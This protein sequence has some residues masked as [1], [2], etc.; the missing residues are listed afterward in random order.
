MM[1]FSGSCSR[2]TTRSRPDEP[3]QQ[4]VGEIVE[5][6]QAL[7]QVGVGLAQHAGAVVGLHPL[8][9]GL[10]RQARGHRLAHAPEPALVVGE[11]AEG[12]QHLP[13]LAVMGHV[14]T[15]DQLVDGQAHL[16]DGRIEAQEFRLDVLG[17]EVLDHHPGLVEHH[18]AEAHAVGQR[19]APLVDRAAKRNAGLDR[20][21]RLQFAGGEHLRHHHGGGLKGLD[22]FLGIDP[23]GAVLDDQDAERIA[24]AQQ[25]H[26]EEGV[27]DLLARLGLIGE[28]R[29]ALGVGERQGLGRRGD[30]ADEALAGAHDG[31]VDGFPV[32]ALGGEKLEHAVAAQHIDGADLRHHVR[33]DLGHDP[34]ETVLRP[35]RLR[36]DLA[37]AAQQKARTAGSTW[38][39][40]SVPVL[41]GPAGRTGGYLL[42]VS[43]P[44]SSLVNQA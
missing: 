42:Q 30:Q 5:I 18:M 14:A 29:V 41:S 11:H 24:G 31:E 22:L 38:H 4:A 16:G 7:A 26:A 25:R 9:G 27:V 12:F 13:V 21:Q 40:L 20:R 36:H 37:E 19:N 43:Q 2:S 23:V 44:D 6:V 15:L 33:G 1:A 17:D 10:R 28:G 8:H 32:Q 3:V 34:V 35:D 39:E